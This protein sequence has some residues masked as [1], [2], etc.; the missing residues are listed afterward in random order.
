MT[1]LSDTLSKERVRHERNHAKVCQAIPQRSG[2]QKECRASSEKN[3][4]Q[5]SAFEYLNNRKVWRSEASTF[6][7]CQ[8]SHGLNTY[9]STSQQQSD[10]LRSG[11]NAY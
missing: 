1:T 11:G 7:Y 6:Q 3:S 9:V 10:H 5:M 8:A 4:C 2:I